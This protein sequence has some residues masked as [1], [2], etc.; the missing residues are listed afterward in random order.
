MNF[1]KKS[2]MVVLTAT[3]T[4]AVT[5]TATIS[6]AQIGIG[7]PADPT[8]PNGPING[9]DCIA[10]QD[11]KD[12][13]SHFSQFSNLT[14][15][16][17]CNDN[18]QTWHLLSSMMFMKRTVFDANMP[19]SK[20]ELFTGKFASDW[21]GY[22]IGRVS[23]IEVVQDCPKG[24]IAYVYGFGGNSM[25]VCPAALT[26][27][28][29]ALDRASVFMHEARHLDGFPHVTCSKGPRAGIQG[30]C[31]TRIAEGGSY[32]VTVE[33]YA[34]LSKYAKGLNPALK[35]YAKASAVVYADEAFENI[36]KI[37]RT[38]QLV[39]LT[40][41]LDFTAITLG[42]MKSE[43]LGKSPV[44]GRIFKRGQHMVLLPTDKNLNGRYVFARNEGEIAQSPGDMITE[45]NAL[46]A[47]QKANLVD[48]HNGAQFTA[49]IYK[50]SVKFTCDPKSPATKDL[51]LPAGAVGAS[52][53]YPNGYDRSA[54]V[55]QLAT[56][57]GDVY[58]VGCQG[59]TPY[60]KASTVRLDQKYTR[61][62]KV[63]GM[64]LG[65]N[66]AGD[67]FNVEPNRST[68]LN[69]NLNSKVIEIAPFQSYEFL[70]TP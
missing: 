8:A 64:T 59:T 12:I 17:F 50:T 55:T 58:D 24:V 49:R 33:T 42:T 67:L 19:K 44:A 54:K 34:Q 65:L 10:Q 56:E 38:E 63:A 29:S 43:K 41:N 36:V 21:Y 30:A 26:D 25:Y 37:N 20:D 62:Y 22:F 2:L 45:Y 28:F 15:K 68:L 5:L 60:I 52:L 18:S 61:V 57:A 6:H 11:L 31:D 32:A 47:A 46:P 39:V 35:A 4:L 48:I 40:E 14:G 53:L 69:L 9:A 3:S 1:F 23:D 70:D 66:Q 7:L 27:S 51:N 13:A 16:D